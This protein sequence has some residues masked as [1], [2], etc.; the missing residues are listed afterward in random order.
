LHQI[1]GE[2]DGLNSFACWVNN[3]DKI[4]SI[5]WKDKKLVNVLSNIY[6]NQVTTS[7]EKQHRERV[8]S[9]QLKPKVL[10][11]YTENG[12]GN[13]D[14]ANHNLVD[15]EAKH[16]HAG[17]RRTHLLTLFK[18]I[19]VNSWII[20]SHL[21]TSRKLYKQPKYIRELVDEIKMQEIMKK[22]TSSKKE[23]RIERNKR[24]KTQKSKN[25]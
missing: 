24:Y 21:D 10:V 3:D 1:L 9:N 15:G 20:Y 23:M 17:W 8:K 19:I 6:V 22:E 11:D 4:A 2:H 25:N 18:F 13:V 14:T 7:M 5:S 12:M 16:K